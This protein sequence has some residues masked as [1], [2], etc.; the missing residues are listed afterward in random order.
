M[1]LRYNKKA[2]CIDWRRRKIKKEV[3]KETAQE[4]QKIAE[5]MEKAR[6]DLQFKYIVGILEA[7]IKIIN[8]QLSERH[9][10]EVI[11]SVNS[12]MKAPESIHAK[13]VRKGYDRDFQTAQEKLNDL[14]GV[15]IICLFLDDVYKVANMLKKQSDIKV[16]K[17]KDYIERSKKNGY[18]SLHLIVEVP[19]GISEQPEVKRVE[20][21]IRTIAMDFWSVLDYQLIYKKDVSGA[22]EVSK[23]LKGYSEEIA[24]LDRKMLKL[25][26]KIDKM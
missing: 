1:V 17:I 7:K 22:E 25:R 26:N 21:Q 3:R 11:R 6:Y 10:R 13:L 4:I 9:G 16:I 20:I 23:E 19:I 14:M 8:E 24:A 15:R 12:R 5:D 2:V 18:M